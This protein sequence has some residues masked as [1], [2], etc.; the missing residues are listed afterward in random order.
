[1]LSPQSYYN[2]HA[3]QTSAAA[4]LALS[5]LTGDT[6]LNTTLKYSTAEILELNE[7]TD[8]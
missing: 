8:L 7:G 6:T 3:T 4:S 2:R 5:A 1:M